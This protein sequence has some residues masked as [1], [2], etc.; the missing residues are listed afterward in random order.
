MAQRITQ[1]RHIQFHVSVSPPES[2]PPYF[3]LLLCL[4]RQLL[5]HSLTDG[6]ISSSSTLSG[7]GSRSGSFTRHTVPS[8]APLLLRPRY[9]SRRKHDR[10]SVSTAL[11]YSWHGCGRPRCV[12]VSAIIW[13][14]IR[15]EHGRGSYPTH[16]WHAAK[17]RSDRHA[18]ELLV[19]CSDP[20]NE[21][22]TWLST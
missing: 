7:C 14:I 6:S 12:F 9:R 3:T 10:G 21:P 20:C 19:I 15:N 11:V 16:E 13:M 1:P 17:Q 22:T 4:F 18:C 2:V 5:I 8:Q